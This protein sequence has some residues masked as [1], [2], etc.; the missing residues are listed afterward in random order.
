MV[1]ERYNARDL[2][3]SAEG[4]LVTKN[5]DFKLASPLQ[6]IKQDASN[7]IKTN[8]PDW[9]RYYNIG[10][11]LEDLFGADNTVKTANQGIE[12]IKNSLS[13][14]ERFSKADIEIEAVPVNK[15]K[16]AFFIFLK[17]KKKDP[18]LIKKIVTLKEE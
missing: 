14:G 9:Y 16:I 6:T 2:E 4:D 18:L 12:K 8:D 3:F 10:S 1:L 7:R 11:N 17:I 13:Y 15:N 5:G